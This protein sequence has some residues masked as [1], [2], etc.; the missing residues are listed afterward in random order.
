MPIHFRFEAAQAATQGD[1]Q[2]FKRE[3]ERMLREEAKEFQEAVGEYQQAHFKRKKDSRGTLTK[4]TKAA[5]NRQIGKTFWRVGIPKHLNRYARYWRT[6]EEGSLST[7]KSGGFRGTPLLLRPSGFPGGR[8]FRS[9]PKK[10][11][12]DFKS[13]GGRVPEYP[14][15]YRGIRMVV[16]RKEIEP[17]NAYQTVFRRGNW[18]ARIGRDFRQTVARYF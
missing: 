16:V 12:R 14:R 10:Y 15:G 6:I 7:F 5:G 3:V 8:P 11:S 13:R 17:M 2:A 1:R 4:A 18:E 9:L